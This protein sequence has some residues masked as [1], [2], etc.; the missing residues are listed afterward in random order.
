MLCIG[1]VRAKHSRAQSLHGR[2][3]M[4]RWAAQ[5]I[6]EKLITIALYLTAAGDPA[7][8]A[9]SFPSH[10]GGRRDTHKARFIN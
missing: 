5:L 8:P 4:L 6:M 10:F 1:I 2:Y 3:Y 7:F 9:K